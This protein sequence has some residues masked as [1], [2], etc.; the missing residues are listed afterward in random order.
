LCQHAIA[1]ISVNGTIGGTRDNP[2]KVNV[3]EDVG[4]VVLC[5]SI[6]F[7][8]NETVSCQTMD[9]TA[10]KLWYIKLLTSTLLLAVAW[11]DYDPINESYSVRRQ[12]EML[13]EEITIKDNPYH[14]GNRKFLFQLSAQQEVDVWVEICIWDDE[15]GM[16][17]IIS[18]SINF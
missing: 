5:Y 16:L 15:W 18:S 7:L 10:G 13:C 8:E 4:K 17:L 6:T 12:E 9:G 14:D 2:G 11:T 1:I 3:S